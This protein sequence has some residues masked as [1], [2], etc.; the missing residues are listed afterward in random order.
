LFERLRHGGD[1]GTER[2]FDQRDAADAG[3]IAVYIDEA[4]LLDRYEEWTTLAKRRPL[5]IASRSIIDAAPVR[6]SGLYCVERRLRRSTHL[7]FCSA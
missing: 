3:A 2:R 6:R 4:D 7:R 5:K 1:R